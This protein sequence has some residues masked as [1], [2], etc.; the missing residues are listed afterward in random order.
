MQTMRV[1]ICKFYFNMQTMWIRVD[2]TIDKIL[3]MWQRLL[4]GR[5]GTKEKTIKITSSFNDGDS[6]KFHAY[7][8]FK[9][10]NRWLLVCLWNET[11]ATLRLSPIYGNI[12]YDHRCKRGE[13]AF[14]SFF[15]KELITFQFA[16]R[17]FFALQIY[18]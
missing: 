5:D 9:Q 6:L 3:L 13:L 14:I 17:F 1:Y 2:H 11:C 12:V 16:Q 18:A 10:K 8:I 15:Y 4:N 7:K